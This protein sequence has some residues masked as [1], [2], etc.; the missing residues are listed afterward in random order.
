MGLHRALQSFKAAS[1]KAALPPVEYYA[2]LSAIF[3]I[4]D[5][6]PAD[7]G[8]DD[9]ANDGGSKVTLFMGLLSTRVFGA[10]SSTQSPFNTSMPIGYNNIESNLPTVLSTNRN[11]ISDFANK[12]TKIKDV[13]VNHPTVSM[14]GGDVTVT[15]AEFLEIVAPVYFSIT[16]FLKKAVLENEIPLRST[17]LIHNQFTHYPELGKK[18]ESLLE[19]AGY[20]NHHFVT[21]EE[22]FGGEWEKQHLNLNLL[23]HQI[24]QYESYSL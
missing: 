18:V 24:T 3:K 13:L 19:D 7:A 20:N 17:I 5:I 14:K 15:K 6:E 10:T 22:L 16:Q 1:Q 8:N 4:S 11:Y 21:T 12:L 23:T 9:V 2:P